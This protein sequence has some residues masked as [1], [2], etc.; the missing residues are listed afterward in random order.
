MSDKL[1]KY[2]NY[3]AYELA[4]ESRLN[5]DHTW[6]WTPVPRNAPGNPKV[7][8]VG[9]STFLNAERPFILFIKYV[10]EKYGTHREEVDII[11]E[12]YR[13]IITDRMSWGG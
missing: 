2:Y 7:Y 4:D 1:E 5:S 3:V 8:G 13:D 11:W 12:L 10:M 9:V 6:L